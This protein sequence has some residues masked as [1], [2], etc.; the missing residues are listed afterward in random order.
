MEYAQLEELVF[1]LAKTLEGTRV[2]VD[3]MRLLLQAALGTI[4][5]HPL[6]PAL[7]STA[8]AGAVEGDTAVMLGSPATDDFLARRHARML[9]LM[10]PT[11]QAK[12]P[13]H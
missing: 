12:A 2:E 3:A 8:L 4:E 6:A 11:L 1:S 10:P 9:Q 7:F 5:A 13:P